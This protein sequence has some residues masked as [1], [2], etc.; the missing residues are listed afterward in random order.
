MNN[1]RTKEIRQKYVKKRFKQTTDTIKIIID[2]TLRIN[3]IDI[4]ANNIYFSHR[5]YDYTMNF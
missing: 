1:L 4:K 3:N 2:D 5:R